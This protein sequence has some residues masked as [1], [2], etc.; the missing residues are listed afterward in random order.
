MIFIQN[1]VCFILGA[2]CLYAGTRIRQKVDNNESLKIPSI[3]ETIEKKKVEKR[4]RD[5]RNETQQI[6]DNI[7]NYPYN[8]KEIR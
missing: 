1:A 3:S 5:E 2:I 7:N 4:E 8:Q 6:L